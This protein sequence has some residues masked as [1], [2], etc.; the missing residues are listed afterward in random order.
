M[1]LVKLI[2]SV[3]NLLNYD[4]IIRFNT[5]KYYFY[6][7]EKVME[8]NIELVPVEN[9]ISETELSL[10]KSIISDGVSVDGDGVI[11][12]KIQSKNLK[13]MIENIVNMK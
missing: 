3:R 6:Q 12:V 13:K 9:K 11:K 8:I 7:K 10:L 2:Q 5:S 4:K 1:N